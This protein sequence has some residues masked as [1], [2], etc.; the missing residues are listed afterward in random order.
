MIRST[1]CIGSI[2]SILRLLSRPKLS[3]PPSAGC[4]IAGLSTSVL[5]LPLSRQCVQL[6][7]Y[8][9][10]LLHSPSIRKLRLEEWRDGNH[11]ERI[12]HSPALAVS[13][14]RREKRF[15]P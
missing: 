6:T 14:L 10:N 7:Q 15:L 3:S 8:L 2:G 5:L 1:V 9:S 4:G 13:Q 12:L 11:D